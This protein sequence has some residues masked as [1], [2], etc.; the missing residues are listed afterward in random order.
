MPYALEPRETVCRLADLF[1]DLGSSH[2][3]VVMAHAAA[4]ED[5][6]I[7]EITEYFERP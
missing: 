4:S 5:P 7:R 2:F 3:S 6:E 1:N